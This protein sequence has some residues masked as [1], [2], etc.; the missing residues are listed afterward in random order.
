MDLRQHLRGDH[1]ISIGAWSNLTDE[2]VIH[3]I[4][5]AGYDWLCIDEQHGGASA[6]DSMRLLA[7]TAAAGAQTLVRVAWN[8]P[9]LIGRALDSGAVGVIVPMVQSASEAANAVRASRYA[10]LGQRSWGPA[11]SGYSLAG[12]ETAEAN[13]RSVCLVMIETPDAVERVAEIA[14]VN[15]LDG[16][17]VGPF[18]LSIA[19]GLP[20]DDLLADDSP[21][22]PLSRVISACRDKGITPGAYD[23]SLARARVLAERGFTMLAVSTDTDLLARAATDA[24]AEARKVLG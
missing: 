9:E 18:D 23:G 13:D 10:P 4:G 20:V 19:L 16:I 15:G 11:R 24:V 7:A 1:A 21:D 3:T 8:R 2:I 22:S 12:P 14:A 5:R 6:G 17:F